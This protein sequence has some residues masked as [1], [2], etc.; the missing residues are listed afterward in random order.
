MNKRFSQAEW[1]VWID[2]LSEKD[3]VV[4]DNFINEALFQSIWC[5]FKEKLDSFERAGI[6]A[7]DKNQIDRN[8][9]SDFTYWLHSKNDKELQD[10]WDLLQ[11]TI[12]VL[13]R[14]CF[15][16][17][18][19]FEFHLAHYPPGGFY[20]KHIDQFSDRNNRM[21]SVIIYLN[22]NWQKGDGG[23][24]EIFLKNDKTILVPP[25]TK[26]CVMFKSAVVPHQV[27]EATKSRYSLTGWLL[28]Q[29][30]MLGSILT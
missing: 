2:Q 16:S 30:P 4:I 7:Q 24:L 14:Y 9:R 17:L 21:I 23:E 28:Y 29:P 15:L 27:L 10:F 22:E 19:D 12:D 11:E 5:F 25:L 18:S 1:L 20:K 8:I 3:Y 13:N 6:G 26:R